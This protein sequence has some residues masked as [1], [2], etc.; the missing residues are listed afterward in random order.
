MKTAARR[1]AMSAAL[2][3]TTVVA[4]PVAAHAD[5]VPDPSPELPKGVSDKTDLGL[6]LLM[7]LGVV[8]VVAGF[9]MAGI[10]MSMSKRGGHGG[11]EAIERLWYVA[12]G[13]IVIG[14][15]SALTGFFLA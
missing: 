1:L 5:D 7:G 8:A 14:S 13:A 2:A 9:I 10:A 12:G 6:N 15:A 11:N 4:A 3:M